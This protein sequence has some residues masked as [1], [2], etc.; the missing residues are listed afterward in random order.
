M[1]F[2]IGNK[3]YKFGLVKAE[4]KAPLKAKESA[5]ISQLTKEFS[6]RSRSDIK[7][8]RDAMQAAE[9]PE[10]P[11]WSLYHDLI[12]NLM[13]DGHLMA[14][15]QVR[16]A[17]TLSNRFYIKDRAT[18]KELA[19]KTEL[20]MTE[21]FYTMVDSLLDSV[22]KGNTVVELADPVVVKWVLWPRR[23]IAP[24]LNRLYFE[25]NGD[26]FINYTD[27]AFTKNVLEFRYTSLFG[28]L[29]DIIPQLIWKRN[30]QQTW[31]DFSERFGIP[32]ISAS[33]TKSDKKDIDRIE[34]MLRALGQSAQALLPEG[35]TITIHDS[36][37]KGD[38][39]KI[40]QEQI[41]TSNDEVSKRVL[42]GT[43][44][45]D[46]GSSRS[47]SEVHER[48]LNEKIAEGDRRSIE[49]FVNGKLIP[50][51]R[52]WGFKFTDNEVFVFDRSEELSLTE[53]WKIVN[54]AAANYE[55]DQEW[56]SSRFNIPIKAAKTK[57][58]VETKP[59]PKAGFSSNFQ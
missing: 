24:Q 44:I 47:Q 52:L 35:T 30:A 17:A 31:A 8:W 45:T 13:T 48:T 3:N 40:F 20:L 49:F 29:N 55:I 56:I 21:W 39:Y 46:S 36:A 33:T 12:E 18:G 4:T 10:N 16:K 28:I 14:A 41:K 27:P 38:P 42:G 59:N 6:D 2:T 37:T 19:D 23:N 58:I 54:E 43:M 15:V 7:K 57:P 5:I 22:F 11:R 25:A 1:E 26:K 51:L 9:N 50:L 34:A 32:L 53:H